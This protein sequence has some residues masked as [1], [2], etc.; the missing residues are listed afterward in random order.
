MLGRP[1]RKTEINSKSFVK[2]LSL[3]ERKLL[4]LVGD[5]LSKDGYIDSGGGEKSTGII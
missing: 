3:V 1:L 2:S 4:K 5:P